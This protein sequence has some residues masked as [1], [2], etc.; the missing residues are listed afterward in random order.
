[1][2]VWLMLRILGLQMTKTGKGFLDVAW[3]R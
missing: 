2:F 3:H 1:M